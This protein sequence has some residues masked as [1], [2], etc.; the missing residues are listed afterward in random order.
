[1]AERTG[2]IDHIPAV[3]VEPD[4]TPAATALWLPPLS[5]N[6]EWVLP[7][8]R[9]LAGA[10]FLAVSFDP[11]QHGERGVESS[12][13]LRAR[14]FSGGF[15]RH[16]WPILGQTTL[17]ALRVLDH[18]DSGD[19]VAGGVS[20]G[21]DV[22]VALAGID[23]SV[24]RVATI[25]STPDW[26]RPGM[27]ELADPSKDLPQGDADDYAQW[28]YNQLDPMSHVERYARGQPILF[29]CGGDDQHVPADGALRFAEAAGDS[30]QVNVR[31]GLGHM[32]AM[33]PEVLQSC[34][35]WLSRR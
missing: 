25:V 14:V 8:L 13:E 32:D 4:A 18:F 19:V 17:D 15:R 27:R 20:M 30:V 29:E 2:W 35:D 10:G 12:E 7:F 26:T 1:M 34:L 3:W 16:M 22:A 31:P 9:E 5:T 33:T 23:P 21:G 28:F 6:K 24:S 11:W